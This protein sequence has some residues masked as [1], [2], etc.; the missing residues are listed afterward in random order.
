[1]ILYETYYNA[2][3]FASC[4]C[5]KSQTQTDKRMYRGHAECDWMTVYAAMISLIYNG[6]LNGAPG[7]F[8]HQKSPHHYRLT[9]EKMS[10]ADIILFV[11]DLWYGE[12]VVFPPHGW[13]SWKG[14][15]ISIRRTKASVAETQFMYLHVYVSLAEYALYYRCQV[16][17]AA[18]FSHSD[19]TFETHFREDGETLVYS[20][21]N[22]PVH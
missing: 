9:D 1:M 11:L 10:R 4:V 22:S 2:G 19:V 21:M 20:E 16:R 7:P 18:L 17:R 12:S 15:G 6:F 3:A 8:R 13:Y 14:L 5:E